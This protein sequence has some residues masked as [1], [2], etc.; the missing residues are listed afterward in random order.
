MT[1]AVSGAIAVVVALASLLP[2]TAHAAFAQ[3]AGTPRLVLVAQTPALEIGGDFSAR[4]RVDGAPSGAALQIRV[5]DRAGTRSAF[6][7]TLTGKGYGPV[8]KTINLQAQAD[9]AGS[10][11]ITIGT[12]VDSTGDPD[13][14]LIRPGVY[15]VEIALRDA[16]SRSIATMTIYLIVLRGAEAGPPLGVALVVGLGGDGP[17]ALQPDG[18]AALSADAERAI[19]AMSAVIAGHPTTP[20]T[21]LAAPEHLAAVTADA[22]RKQILGLGAG[23]QVA[24]APL[25]PIDTQAWLGAGITDDLVSELDAGTAA[26]TAIVAAPQPSTWVSDAPV[27]PATATWLVDQRHVRDFVVPDTA[28]SALDSKRFNTTLL[29]PFLVDGVSGAR[30]VAADT[31]LAKHVGETGDTVL[32]ANHL[33]ADLAILD[34]DLPKATRLAVVVVPQSASPSLVDA[35][36]GGLQATRTL[37]PGTVDQLLASVPTAGTKGETDG[38]GTPLSRSLVAPATASLGSFPARLR[39]ARD[40]VVTYRGALDPGDPQADELDR[41]ALVAGDRSLA[42]NDQMTRLDAVSAGVRSDLAKVEAPPRQTITFTARDG[43][44]S[45][46]VR[47]TSGHPVHVVLHLDGPRLELP[48]HPDGLVP[49]TLSG[50]DETTRVEIDVRARASGDSPLDVSIATPDGR[51][52]LGRTRITVRST[53]LS[54][55]GVVLSVGALVFLL[56]WWGRH[57]LDARRHRNRRPRHAIGAADHREPEP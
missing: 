26:L 21:L 28:V 8:L 51:I 57:T 3:A 6:L 39:A 44:V 43:V 5:H 52:T 49:L 23:R 18:T 11:P 29:Q 41:R 47:N 13:R 17:P 25:V 9:S 22:T 38:T 34:Q 42:T 40:D 36:L 35:V 55:V 24:P 16:S 7:Q 31:T 14:L 15:P 12:R 50:E 2:L 19:A 4:V 33:L 48:G 46:A 45:L 20:L 56:V 30:A 1:R 32:D 53:A 54:G 10:V 27:S 37:R